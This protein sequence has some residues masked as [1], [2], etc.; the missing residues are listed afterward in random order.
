[1]TK[2]P[3]PTDLNDYYRRRFQLLRNGADPDLLEEHDAVNLFRRSRRS[4]GTIEQRRAVRGAL[5]NEREHRE[6]RNVVEVRSKPGGIR[7]MSGCASRYG[8]AYE[9]EDRLG[10]YTETWLEGCAKR[11]INGGSQI[12]TVN[13]NFDMVPL[14]RSRGGQGTMRTWEEPDGL[15]FDADLDTSREDVR[16]LL[17]AIQREDLTGCSLSFRSIRE[18]WN[19]D[20]TA[21][22][23]QEAAIFELSVVS[24]PA[25]PA[26]NGSLALAGSRAVA[27]VPDRSGEYR[28]R[29]AALLR[30]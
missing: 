16:A 22:T 29:L 14:A 15:M 9:I 5:H 4:S 13:H 8:V 19:D 24:D 1:M 10:V 25:N 17:S 18:T 11:S 26:T 7:S 12:L 3:T 2:R 28:R 23:I 27:L 30:G 6:V 20:Y 21:R